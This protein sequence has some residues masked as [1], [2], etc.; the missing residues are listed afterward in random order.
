MGRPV[1]PFRP[2]FDGAG[3]MVAQL[4]KLG[5]RGR[6]LGMA[7]S[8]PISADEEAPLS[9]VTN[10]ELAWRCETGIWSVILRR[11]KYAGVI[12]KADDSA[13]L[14]LVARTDRLAWRGA[15]D[16]GAGGK[17]RV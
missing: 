3:L 12:R 15:V 8:G 17:S 16:A 10:A 11:G 7:R 9:K 1:M 13:L 5:L 4:E 14:R 2:K 6:A